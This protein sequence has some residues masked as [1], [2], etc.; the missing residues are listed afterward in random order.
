MGGYA[1]IVRMITIY[2]QFCASKVGSVGRERSEPR[3]KL[4]DVQKIMSILIP[5]FSRAQFDR[6]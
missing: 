5:H 4:Q 2:G 6:F 1:T 3:C